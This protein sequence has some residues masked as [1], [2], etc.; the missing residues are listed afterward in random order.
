M[1]AEPTG[2]S[3]CAHAL[4]EDWQKW[5]LEERGRLGEQSGEPLSISGKSRGRKGS[6]VPNGLIKITPSARVWPLTGARAVE[7]AAVAVTPSQR[8]VVS[9]QRW[10][11]TK[12]GPG[13]CIQETAS[14]PLLFGRI[15]RPCTFWRLDCFHSAVFYMMEYYEDWMKHFIFSQRRGGSHTQTNG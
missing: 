14:V 5:K 1:R 4:D 8:L 6:A 3:V 12:G 13:S 10:D 15:T 9:C 11:W 2:E 7:V